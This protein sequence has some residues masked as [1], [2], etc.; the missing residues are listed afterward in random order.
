M[1]FFEKFGPLFEFEKTLCYDDKV[2]KSYDNFHI[3]ILK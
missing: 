3:I 1:S 2:E